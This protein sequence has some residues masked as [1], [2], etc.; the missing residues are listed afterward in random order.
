MIGMRTDWRVEVFHI[1]HLP[2]GFAG[3]QKDVIQTMAEEY[4]APG[5]MNLV[6]GGMSMLMDLAEGIPPIRT[7]MLNLVCMF[8]RIE[9]TRDD[10][11]TPGR[12]FMHPAVQFAQL[13][14]ILPAR[15]AEMRRECHDLAAGSIYFHTEGDPA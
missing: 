14:C 4:A 2:G 3:L 15:Q 11:G 1:H 5:P 12:Y 6:C 10:G 8:G 7:D 13:F 9:V